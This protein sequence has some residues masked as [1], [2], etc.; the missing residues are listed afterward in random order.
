MAKIIKTPNDVDMILSR[1]VMAGYEAVIIGG[2]V[3]D[4][5]M[6]ITPHDWDIAT[7]A[8]PTEIMELFS[9]YRLMTAG[10][11]HGTVTVIIDHEPYEITTYR[12]DGK[13]SGFRRPDSVDFTCDLSEDIMRRDFTINAIAYDGEKIIDLHDGI[14]D[15]QRG[16]IRCVGSA[17]ERFQE[18]PLRILR[19]IRFA[20]RFDFTIEKSTSDAMRKYMHLLDKIAIE[21]KQSEF[22]KIICSSG[23]EVLKEYPDILNFVMPGIAD[24][25]NWREVVDQINVSQDLCEKLAIIIDKLNI[26]EYNDVVELVAKIMKYPNNVTK[27]IC[28]IIKC[29]KE[30]ITD[31]EICIRC[32]LSKYPAEDVIK[33]INYKIAKISHESK[34]EIKTFHHI[35]DIIAEIIEKPDVF[36]YDLKHLDINGHD[37]KAIGIPEI[38]IKDYLS[39]LLY[40]VMTNQIENRKEKLIQVVNNSIL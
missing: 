24:I 25:K 21:R 10:L 35:K 38:K 33:T 27:S 19:A 13:Y 2:C 1:L 3:R 17:E 18:D 28:N 37:L 40:M 4:S 26:E 11:K 7:S 36:C 30:L 20:A 16:I 31:S 23:K 6:G 5:I 22:S 29:K 14:G 32:L 9:D 12:V 39:N 15:L 8:Q 34:E